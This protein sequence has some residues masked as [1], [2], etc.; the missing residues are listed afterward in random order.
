MMRFIANKYRILLGM[1][2]APGLSA[3][4][5]L[6]RIS[7]IGQEPKFLAIENPTTRPGYKP[8]RMPMPAPVQAIHNPNSFWRKRS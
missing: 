4:T 8:I 5:A 3:C 6:N 1:L 2:V 7:E